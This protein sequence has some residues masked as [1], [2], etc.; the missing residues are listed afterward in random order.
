M[1]C[2]EFEWNWNQIRAFC[3]FNAPARL[4]SVRLNS[5]GSLHST[6][7][8]RCLCVCV[9]VCGKLIARSER[10]LKCLGIILLSPFGTM[11]FALGCNSSSRSAPICAQ[12]FPFQWAFGAPFKW[13]FMQILLLAKATATATVTATCCHKFHAGALLMWAFSSASVSLVKGVSCFGLAKTKNKMSFLCCPMSCVVS[14]ST[15]EQLFSF[16]WALAVL[17]N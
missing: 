8:K 6:R 4:D 3:W 15:G 12:K 16:F 2:K 14:Q 1:R 17:T 5:Q 10:K 7:A 9:C 13:I 11:A